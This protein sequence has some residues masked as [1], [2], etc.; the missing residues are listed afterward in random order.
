MCAMGI[1][2]HSQ[3]RTNETQDETNET[4]ELKEIDLEYYLSKSGYTIIM[5]AEHDKI[6]S[7]HPIK[8]KG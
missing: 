5:D 6:Y 4:N 2:Q 7:F 8:Q 1:D 3:D